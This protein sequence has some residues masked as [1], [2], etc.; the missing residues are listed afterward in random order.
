MRACNFNPSACA[1]CDAQG[2]HRADGALTAHAEPT[3]GALAC[4][5]MSCVAQGEYVCYTGKSEGH[6]YAWTYRGSFAND[7]MDG[8]GV[9]LY[10][11]GN[12]YTGAF[13]KG[14]FEGD[15]VFEWNGKGKEGNKYLG[16]YKAGKRCGHGVMTLTSG[17]ECVH[18]HSPP[19]L[20][21]LLPLRHTVPATLHTPPCFPSTP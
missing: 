16:R 4:V 19:L 8:Q 20:R 11:T 7:Q 21:S 17:N 6:A 12:V 15:G 18:P 14:V 2:M 3:N 9:L 10:G 13:V 1:L 5:R